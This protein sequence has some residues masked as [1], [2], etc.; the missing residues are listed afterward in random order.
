MLEEAGADEIM[1]TT[2]VC[3]HTDCR[4]SYE[5]LGSFMFSSGISAFGDC[6]RELGKPGRQQCG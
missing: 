5:L 6:V 4:R 3:N 1:V 2:P